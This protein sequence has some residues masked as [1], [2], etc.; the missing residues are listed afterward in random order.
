M[1]NVA[2]TINLKGRGPDL[3]KRLIWSLEKERAVEIHERDTIKVGNK[4]CFLFGTGMVTN[5]LDEVYSGTEKGLKRNIE[6]AAMTA[7]EAVK[8][9]PDGKIFKMTEGDVIIDG[10]KIPMDKVNGILSATVEHVGMGFSPLIDAES[11]SHAF[12]TIVISM[13]PRK[14]LMN[15][16]KIRKGKHIKSDGY[17]NSMTR[18]MTLKFPGEFEYTMDG[19]MYTAIDE[20]YVE[21]GPRIRLVKV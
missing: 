9:S 21:T 19:D 17:F 3:I 8:N 4:Y 2:R 15:I 18:D 10:R 11:L 12:Q 5:F 1:N 7:L 20:L 13:T 6:V 14:I 16:N